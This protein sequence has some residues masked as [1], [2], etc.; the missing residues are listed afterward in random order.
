MHALLLSYFRQHVLKLTSTFFLY[1]LHEK[2]GS[3]GSKIIDKNF[4][5]CF[6]PD[7]QLKKFLNFFV[8]VEI[9]FVAIF[10][11]V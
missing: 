6:Y 4:F 8:V 9:K 11:Q 10:S 7:K 2:K 1:G 3:R 5:N